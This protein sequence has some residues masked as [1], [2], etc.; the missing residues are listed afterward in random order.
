M[1]EH[2]AQLSG[3][4]AFSSEKF[5]DWRNAFLN[6]G[7]ALLLSS[8]RRISILERFVDFCAVLEWDWE[9]QWRKKLR[10]TP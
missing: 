3:F 2:Y 1:Q 7:E 10:T 4:E 9:T 8:H 6:E 5:D